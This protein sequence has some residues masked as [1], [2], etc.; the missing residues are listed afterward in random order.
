MQVSRSRGR[1]PAAQKSARSARSR[2]RAVLVGLFAVVAALTLASSASAALS[3]TGPTDPSNN[4]PS[5]YKDANGISLQICQDGLPNCLSGPE[6]LQD[7]H[8]A[9]GDAEAFYWSAD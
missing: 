6:L 7:T 5:F 2:G 8:A 3:S 1:T 4:F 9:G